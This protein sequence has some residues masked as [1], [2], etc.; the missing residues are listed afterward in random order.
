MAA[1]SGSEMVISHIL[2]ALAKPWQ[3][4]GGPTNCESNL[5]AQYS[6]SLCLKLY[7]WAVAIGN[8]GHM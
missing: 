8:C 5:E 2:V 7:Y 4:L 6:C 1:V 3:L